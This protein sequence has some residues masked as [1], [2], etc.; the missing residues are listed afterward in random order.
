MYLLRKPSPIQTP[1]Q[2]QSTVLAVSCT[3]RHPANMAAVQNNTESES[4]VMS[5]APTAINGTAAVISTR[6]N[7]ARAVTSSAKKR[8]RRKLKVAA[9]TGEKKRTPKAVSPHSEVPRNCV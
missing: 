9:M 7:P 5:T 8:S 3:A 1:T 2:S 4:T 6:K